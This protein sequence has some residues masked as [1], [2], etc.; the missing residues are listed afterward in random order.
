MAP[1]L[2]LHFV[3]AVLVKFTQIAHHVACIEPFLLLMQGLLA[4]GNVIS[5]PGDEKLR[6]PGGHAHPPPPIPLAG[7]EW[8]AQREAVHSCF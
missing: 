7:V 2:L 1:L 3:F 5:A 8:D 4:L 6:L